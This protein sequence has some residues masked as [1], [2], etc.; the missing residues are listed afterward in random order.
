MPLDP[1][2]R[3]LDTSVCTN[4]NFACSLRVSNICSFN[5]FTSLPL[6]LSGKF[7]MTRDN[8]LVI[9]IKFYL[10]ISV[11][12]TNTEILFVTLYY[13]LIYISATFTRTHWYYA[14]IYS[15]SIININVIEY[16]TEIRTWNW[17]SQICTFWNVLKFL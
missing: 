1:L 2:Q 6:P 5:R 7:I 4:Y 17:I 8:I 10:C 14:K 12:S 9:E 16:K 15:P 11:S 13:N 3:L